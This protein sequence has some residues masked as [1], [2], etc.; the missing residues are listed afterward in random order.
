MYTF[1]HVFKLHFYVYL[2]SCFQTTCIHL[3]SSGVTCGAGLLTLPEHLSSPTIVSGVRVARSLVFC[4][5]LCRSCFVFFS[6]VLYC[7]VMF[8]IVQLCFVLFSY[9]LYCLS[10]CLFFFLCFLSFSGLRLLTTPLVSL[11]FSSKI[12]QEQ[13]DWCLI[14]REQYL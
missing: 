3:L 2:C 14:P 1:V 13:I 11:S 8:C 9:V 12:T 6:Y 4:V 5:M 7:L 10:F